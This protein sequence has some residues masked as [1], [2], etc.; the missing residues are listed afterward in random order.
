M[1]SMYSLGFRASTI[2]AMAEV[3][4]ASSIVVASSATYQRA[5]RR[6]PADDAWVDEDR[7]TLLDGKGHP[8]ELG[9][10]PVRHLGKRCMLG[11][12]CGVQRVLRVALVR[13]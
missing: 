12:E 1:K 11:G 4:R 2:S 10:E 9:G 13:L 3:G 8:G 5:V 7:L 6:P